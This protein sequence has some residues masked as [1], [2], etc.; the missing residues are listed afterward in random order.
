VTSTATFRPARD[1]T[2]RDRD[3]T[4]AVTI[5]RLT[6]RY[7]DNT[8][9]DNLTFR[10]EPGR[11]T[12]F[13]G[14]NGSGKSTTMKVLVGLASATAGEALIGG[15]SYGELADPART[16]GAILEPNAFHPGRTGRN[17]LRIVADAAG[18]AHD[19]VDD[20]LEA[21]GLGARG[22]DRRVGAYS[23]GMRQRLSLAGALL[24]DPP[25]MVLDEP[26]NGLDP[27]GI[28]TL[29]NLLR[30][31]AAE[32]DTVLVSSHLLAEIEQLADDVVIIDEGRLVTSGSLAALRQT[33][34]LVRTPRPTGL[35]S[36]IRSAGGTVEQRDETTLVVRGMSTD[37]IGEHAFSTGHVLHELSP[38]GASLED[39]FLDWTTD[40]APS[41][42]GVT[43]AIETEVES[44][45]ERLEVSS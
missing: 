3:R 5:E 29:R 32:G 4:Y 16:V 36:V 6:K 22:G 2:R 39:Q 24:G 25:V 45:T 44:A 26:A 13:L 19:R 17:H 40:A 12:G 18:I 28:R 33:A 1:T 9:V 43:I 20:M 14:P 21:V 15:V 8:V 38:Y 34:S 27:Q 41:D 37:Q 42:D 7:G 35:A 11:V 31:R 30:A 10:A 23:L